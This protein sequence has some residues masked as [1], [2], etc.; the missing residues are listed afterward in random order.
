MA[1]LEDRCLHPDASLKR[2]LQNDC[3]VLRAALAALPEGYRTNDELE[4]ALQ[5][6]GTVEEIAAVLAPRA[7][8]R[9]RIQYALLGLKQVLNAIT[10]WGRSGRT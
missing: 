3:D 10:S 7:G 2:Y 5:L 4:C 1:Q 8:S 6:G 9:W